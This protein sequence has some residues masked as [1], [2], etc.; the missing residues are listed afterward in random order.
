M[1]N[2]EYTEKTELCFPHNDKIKIDEVD[3]Y[4]IFDSISFILEELVSL[5]SV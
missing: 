3:I 2:E 1:V 5:F 4:M